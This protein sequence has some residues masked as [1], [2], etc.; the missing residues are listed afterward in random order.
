MEKEHHT[1]S[2][3]FTAGLGMKP[4][5]ASISWTTPQLFHSLNLLSNSWKKGGVTN[6]GASSNTKVDKSALSLSAQNQL[7][8]LFGSSQHKSKVFLGLTLPLSSSGLFSFHTHSS[9][10]F[11]L[12]AF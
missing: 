5:S 10:L 2:V 9:F 8:H 6:W 4:A 1:T 12:V 3:W 7:L 11:P